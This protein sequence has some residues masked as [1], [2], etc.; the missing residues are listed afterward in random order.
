M[1]HQNFSVRCPRYCPSLCTIDFGTAISSCISTCACGL[2]FVK[3]ERKGGYGMCGHQN[4]IIS[5]NVMPVSGVWGIWWCFAGSSCI[6]GERH[7]SV[8]A[9]GEKAFLVLSPL[10][11]RNFMCLE[12]LTVFSVLPCAEVSTGNSCGNHFFVLWLWALEWKQDGSSQSLSS[13]CPVSKS[14]FA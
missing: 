14:S 7:G 10:P 9:F 11:F 6:R 2:I 1:T 3:V 12:M 4:S 13:H 5:W 8:L